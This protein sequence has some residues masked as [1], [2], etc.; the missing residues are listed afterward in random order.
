[1]DLMAS[2]PW[3]NICL[4]GS[5]LMSETQLS[6]SGTQCLSQVSVHM[7][8]QHEALGPNTYAA[9]QRPLPLRHTEQCGD[10]VQQVSGATSTAGL[11]G[12]G[13]AGDTGCT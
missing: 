6:N 7:W 4:K 3:L 11:L 5:G 12:W 2:C 8:G 9:W 13:D 10:E 1:M